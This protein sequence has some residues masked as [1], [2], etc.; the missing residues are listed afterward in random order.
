MSGV[1]VGGPEALGCAPYF[2]H[3]FQG[4]AEQLETL[5]RKVPDCLNSLVPW[6]GA[7]GDFVF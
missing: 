4:S 1:G 2:P 7:S 6:G 5:E 3:S